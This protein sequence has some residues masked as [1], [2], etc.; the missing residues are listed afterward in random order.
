MVRHPPLMVVLYENNEGGDP[1]NWTGPPSLR[2]TVVKKTR[3]MGIPNSF[4]IRGENGDVPKWGRSPSPGSLKYLAMHHGSLQYVNRD[5]HA[6]VARPVLWKGRLAKVVVI[7][8]PER[9]SSILN[10]QVMAARS[11]GLSRRRSAAGGW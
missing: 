9:D 5:G 3:G 7:A 2:A 6:V 4:T 11:P 1:A 8:V 10:L